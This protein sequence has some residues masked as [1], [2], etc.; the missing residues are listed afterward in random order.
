MNPWLFRLAVAGSLCVTAT[1][2]T[3][4]STIEDYSQQTVALTANQGCTTYV[5]PVTMIRGGTDHTRWHDVAIKEICN[6]FIVQG[7]A[8]TLL[9]RGDGRVIAAN[10]TDLQNDRFVGDIYSGAVFGQQ[11]VRLTIN[12]A[13][14]A[15]ITPRGIERS[16]PNLALALPELQRG[17]RH[18]APQMG[19]TARDIVVDV[20][21]S[22]NNAITWA[23]LA[24]PGHEEER[25]TVTERCLAV[26]WDVPFE[27]QMICGARAALIAVT[28]R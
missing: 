3:A 5:W 20:T 28:P 22:P 2:A 8:L 16:M 18:F 15:T 11:P 26:L 1:T 14:G 27:R 13:G 12:G 9:V 17:I 21:V 10:G 6:A 24:D 4:Q 23:G 19:L 7:G 25:I